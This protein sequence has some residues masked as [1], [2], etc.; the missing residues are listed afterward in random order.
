MGASGPGAMPRPID[1]DRLLI[2]EAGAVILSCHLDN[3]S[4]SVCGDKNA[5]LTHLAAM[6]SRFETSWT[7]A[8]RP[9]RSDSPPNVS[10]PACSP[11]YVRQ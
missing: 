11:A 2:E 10:C 6:W 8:T 1:T 3:W 5:C 7:S 9:R 4:A